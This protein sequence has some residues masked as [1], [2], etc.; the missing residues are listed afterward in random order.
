MPTVRVPISYPYNERG[1][2]SA[3]KDAYRINVMEERDGEHVYT[4]KRP[5]LQAYTVFPSGPGQGL[6]FYNGIFYTVVNDVLYCS[7]SAGYSGST[8]THWTNI[9]NAPWSIRSP[10]GAVVLNDEF[11]ILGGVNTTLTKSYNDIW[12]TSDMVNWQ[13]S[14][15][16][17][18]WGPRDGFGYAVLNER[19]Y[20]I[21]GT[22]NVTGIKYNDVWSSSDGV[23]WTQDTGSAAFTPRSEMGVV[24]TSNGIF[25]FGGINQTPAAL[26]EIWYSSDGVTWV[27]VQ[28]NG[29]F[30]SARSHMAVYFYHNTFYL[31]GGLD[32]TTTAKRDCWSSPNAQTWT[33]LSATALPSAR[34][35]PGY[36]VYND[37]MFMVGGFD[38]SAAAISSV[39]TSTDGTTWTQVTGTGEF[40]P[41][42]FA[43]AVPY[44][45]PTSVSPYR[46]PT[47]WFCGGISTGA[48]TFYNTVYYATLDTTVPLTNVLS[49]D[50]TGQPY[51]MTSFVEGTKM[52]IK[53]QSNLYVWDSGSVHKVVDKGYPAVTVPGIVV[54]GGFAYVMSPDG[55]I[56]NCVLDDPYHWP[57]LNVIGADYDDDAGVAIVKYQNYLV[58]FGLNSMQ[59]FYD[60]GNPVGSPLLPYLN[61]NM[62]IGCA[63]ASTVTQI[64][65]TVVWVSQTKQL[66][67]QVMVLNGL[68]PQ[69]ISTPFI[70]RIL[71]ENAENNINGIA[72]AIDGHTFYVLNVGSTTFV[73]DFT[74]KQWFE[75]VFNPSYTLPFKF[76]GYATTFQPGGYY[77]LGATDGTV[78]KVSTQYYTDNGI[79]FQVNIQ[80]IKVDAGNNRTKFWGQ[81]EVIGDR[82]VGQPTIYYS[83]DDYNTFSSGR[84]VNMNTSRPVLYRNGSS[85]RRSITYVQ[86]DANPM[87]L[88]AFEMTYE[89][90]N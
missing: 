73:Y 77:V 60:A 90:G 61:S 47:I 14:V 66:G 36:C 69:A 57:S 20:V 87:R 16:A 76:G 68:Q 11:Y 56:Q 28:T 18:P 79:A 38:N 53:N 25:L 89:Q 19:I 37:K 54:L 72:M 23:E 31:A 88:E 83:D 26:A 10:T 49:P 24:A 29:S 7:G 52:L 40:G 8:G 86:T 59:F 27:Q 67:R 80:T 1:T 35:I 32:G 44:R 51:Q 50:T 13:Q 15:G 12:H 65:S 3:D 74:T 45:T 62:L 55:L 22:N 48:T 46:Y 17:A 85:R 2:T 6:N 21:G 58:A 43:Q 30:W 33:Q 81:F 64:G 9:T 41:K 82:N 63:A 42:G 84:T 34:Y 75:W 4:V 5:G 71:G 39:L 70:D 78:Y